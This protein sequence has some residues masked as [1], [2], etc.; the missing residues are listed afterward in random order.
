MP[1]KIKKSDYNF[2]KHM[3][4]LVGVILAPVFYKE[5]AQYLIK[6]YSSYTSSS[7]THLNGELSIC[8]SIADLGVLKIALATYNKINPN[9]QITNMKTFFSS[10]D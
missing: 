1:S 7:G 9:T 3:R 8:E 5:K 4:C 2:W 6:Q 10:P